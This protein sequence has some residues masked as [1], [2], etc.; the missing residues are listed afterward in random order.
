MECCQNILSLYCNYY[1]ESNS[2]S[3]RFYNHYEN[4]MI[5]SKQNFWWRWNAYYNLRIRLFLNSA[6]ISVTQAR[7]IMEKYEGIAYVT[8]NWGFY[9][10]I[11]MFWCILIF[12]EKC[13]TDPVEDGQLV[14]TLWNFHLCFSH[15]LCKFSY[16]L[17]YPYG[18]FCYYV[19]TLGNFHLIFPYP[20][21]I[22]QSVKQK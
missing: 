2:L 7:N 20:M 16:F 6:S 12:S 8:C 21:E 11:E 18:N 3:I 19:S 1:N 17:S 5:S 14:D 4:H 9:R 10:F 13:C 15:T 22:L